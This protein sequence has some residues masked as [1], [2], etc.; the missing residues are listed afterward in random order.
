ML[1]LDKVGYR[2]AGR[3]I[4][5]QQ[6]LTALPGELLALVGPNGAGKSTLLGLMSG[7]LQPQQ[8][9]VCLDKRPL[10]QWSLAALAK[11]RAVLSQNVRLHFHFTVKE[12]VALGLSGIST[13]NDHHIVMQALAAAQVVHLI[14]QPYPTLSGGEQR[15]VQFAR[16]LAQVWNCRDTA[17]WL[18][19]DEPD[20]GL[21]I[22]HQNTMLEQAKQF[23]LLGYGVVVVL[24]DLNLAARH[25]D[26]IA[27]LNHGDI[28]AH[29]KPEQ[30]LEPALLSS[31]YG[32]ALQRIQAAGKSL[33]TTVA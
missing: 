2:T 19:L 20:A 33:I 17:G 27:L 9:Q 22:A 21:D 26:R 25:A 8:G 10:S 24:H 30:V 32:I 13:Q 7:R 28:L 31:V 15:Q 12:V 6:S 23:A 3:W 16:T 14:D 1:S 5:Q 18:L 11:R 29:G 4:I